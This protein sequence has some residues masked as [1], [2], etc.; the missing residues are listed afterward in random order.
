MRKIHLYGFT[1][2]ELLIVVAIIGILAAIAIPNFLQAQVRAKVA[3]C[4]ENQYSI[5]VALE[6][7][8]ID[9]NAYPPDNIHYAGACWG[10]APQIPLPLY[11]LST[12]VDYL[13]SVPNNVFPNTSW[14]GLY[15]GTP[16]E[17][18]YTYWAEEWRECIITGH[19]PPITP[20]IWSVSS[21]GPNQ[22][23]NFGSYLIFGQDFLNSILFIQW[24]CLYDPTNGTISDGDIVR[25]GP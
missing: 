17:W 24:G 12:P 9:A 4:N 13:S 2:I 21:M 11:R 7:Y 15:V 16:Q 6:A 23:D 22:L 5:G 14:G 18:Y 25:V 20:M 3:H 10:G 1:L 19:D 8:R